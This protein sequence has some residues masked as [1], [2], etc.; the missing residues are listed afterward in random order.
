MS[1]AAPLLVVEGLKKYYPVRGGVFGAKIG[2]VR[3]VDGVNLSVR[4][5]ETLG[6]VGESGCG[7]STLGRTVMRLEEP[8]EGRVY[9][10]GKELA[11]ASKTEL[12]QLRRNIQVIFQDPYSSLN[13]RM[14]VGEILA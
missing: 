1:E 3:A 11:K 10:E 14:T 2:D 5:G 9:F 4:H 6:L 7:K 8:T 13:P 12:F